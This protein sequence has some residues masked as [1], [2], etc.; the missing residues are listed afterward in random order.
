MKTL[1]LLVRAYCHLCDEMLAAVQPLAAAHDVTL[2]VIDVDAP[3]N[4]ALEAAWGER[5][6]VLFA[7][8]PQSGGVLCHYHLD[9]ARVLTALCG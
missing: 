7:G 3:A 1:T 5:V 4:A 2:E 8:P 6:P 9:R